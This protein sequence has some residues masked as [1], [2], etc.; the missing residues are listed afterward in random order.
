MR[1][2]SEVL[3]VDRPTLVRTRFGSWLLRGVQQ[4]VFEDQADGTRLT[5]EFWTNGIISAVMA[6]VF[7]F[8][9]YK[10]SFRGELMSFARW[11]SAKRT[12]IRKRCWDNARIC[13]SYG[14]RWPWR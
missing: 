14:T 8:G 5:Q 4:V 13:T 2:P 1:S 6:R 12:P 3:Q 10:G 7:S 11:R 9:S